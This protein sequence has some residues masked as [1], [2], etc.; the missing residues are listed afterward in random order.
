MRTHVYGVRMR[1]N[2]ELH[3]TLS[4]NKE[5]EISEQ[6]TKMWR[7]SSKVH[8]PC[9]DNVFHFIIYVKQFAHLPFRFDCS[10]L[11]HGLGDAF[12]AFYMECTKRIIS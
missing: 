11:A 8:A 5:K 1:T 4:P 10:M 2:K 12:I 3:Y 7:K 9:A 6:K